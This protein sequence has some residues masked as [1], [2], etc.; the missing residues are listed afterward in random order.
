MK[1]MY[2][3]LLSFEIIF[4]DTG[5]VYESKLLHIALLDTH[6]LNPDAIDKNELRL[7]RRNFFEI[8]ISK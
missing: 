5:S 3:L 7:Q 6:S 1:Y 8:D 4:K 2:I